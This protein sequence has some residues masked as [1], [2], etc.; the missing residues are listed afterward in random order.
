MLVL[1]TIL[2][3]IHLKKIV[4]INSIEICPLQKLVPGWVFGTSRVLL[5]L[6]FSP[7][8][9]GTNFGNNICIFMGLSIP[10]LYE[11]CV[12]QF[13]SEEIMTLKTLKWK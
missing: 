11:I 2:L 3:A 10:P 7:Y 9:F 5:L 1:S 6:I 13:I 4:A 12:S 8:S